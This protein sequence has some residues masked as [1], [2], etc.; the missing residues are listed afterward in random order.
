MNPKIEKIKAE[1][2]R[3]DAKVE[4][5]LARN[6]ELAEELRVLEDSD[7]LTMVREI[8]MG[9]KELYELLQSL[10]YQP[11]PKHIKTKPKEDSIE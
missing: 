6:K 11:S 2:Q 4:K 1:M 9:P 5:C 10:S 3:N 7:I 8:G